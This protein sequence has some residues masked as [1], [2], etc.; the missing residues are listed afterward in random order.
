MDILRI[1]KIS[2]V[3]YA[4]G[5]ARVLYTDRDNAVT[6]ELPLLSAEYY[7]PQPDDVVL[8]AHLPNGAEAGIVLGRFWCDGNRPPESGAGL[9]RKDL[10]REGDCFIK[11][12]NGEMTIHC[13]GGIHI[14]GDVTV[15]G[16]IT[17]T[18]TING[19]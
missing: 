9:Y 18:G 1:G 7:M 17:A 8:V 4:D 2:S 16:N 3:N 11:C 12:Q 15:D 6:A 14:K 19:A 13:P 5:T 10:S